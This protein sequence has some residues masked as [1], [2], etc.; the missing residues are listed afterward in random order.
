MRTKAEIRRQIRSHR[1]QLTPAEIAAASSAIETRLLEL[2]AVRDAKTWSVYVSAGSEVRTHRLIQ[3]L[4]D[5]SAIVAVPC[6][7]GP[8]D[9]VMQ[10]I[11]SFDELMATSRGFLEPAVD[12]KAAQQSFDVCI[13]PGVAFTERGDRL[14]SGAGFYDRY[15]A[16]N[17]S[18]L[19]I[20]LALDLQIV[21]ELPTE[22][23][24][25]RMDFLITE[26]RTLQ[27]DLASR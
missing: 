10:R 6:V 16:G 13:C 26:K 19:C 23:H 21:A 22:A 27:A 8:A 18:R 14:G 1:D 3:T 17:P 7:V 24:D 12:S 2:A 4:L 25:R 20:G 11:H 9:M 5:R 15:L